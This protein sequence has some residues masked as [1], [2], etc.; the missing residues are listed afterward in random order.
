MTTDDVLPATRYPIDPDAVTKGDEISVE[1][2]TKLS[3]AEGGSQRYQLFALALGNWIERQ[4]AERGEH[5]VVVMRKGAL[6]IL[7][8]REIPAYTA[9]R[10]RESLGIQRRAI[11][12]VG[13]VDRSQLPDDAA[14]NQ[15]DRQATS[16]AAQYTAARNAAR[17]A[18]RILNPTVQRAT[19]ATLGVPKGPK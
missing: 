17:A 11:Q 5:V 16:M 8:D 19:P 13:H 1:T 2:L 14:R 15:L 9:Q 12:A 7:L 10:W 3:G 4:K 6:R 18:A